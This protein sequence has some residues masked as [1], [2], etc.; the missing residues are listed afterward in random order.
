MM[1]AILR[2]QAP[3]TSLQG[4]ARSR[5]KSSCLFLLLP[6]P[7]LGGIYFGQERPVLEGQVNFVHGGDETQKKHI[8][9]RPIECQDTLSQLQELRVNGRR[10][11]PGA[12][13]TRWQFCT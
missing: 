1:V 5:A 4:V 9:S 12:V 10:E 8:F 13:H 11:E 2:R 6:L 7:G 3:S